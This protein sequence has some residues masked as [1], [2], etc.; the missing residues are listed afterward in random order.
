[1]QYYQKELKK[2]EDASTEAHIKAQVQNCYGVAGINNEYLVD[3][4]GAIHDA[5]KGYKIEDSSVNIREDIFD[6]IY[7]TIF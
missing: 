6:N 1:M 5:G 3:R 7:S 4:G 2:K